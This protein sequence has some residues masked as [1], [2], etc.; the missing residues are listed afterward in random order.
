MKQTVEQD[1]DIVIEMNQDV[2]RLSVKSLGLRRRSAAS[3]Q[4]ETLYKKIPHFCFCHFPPFSLR[5]RERENFD[6]SQSQ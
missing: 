3:L 4:D 1:E 2:P 6:M 5:E